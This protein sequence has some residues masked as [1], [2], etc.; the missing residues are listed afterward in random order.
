M[1]KYSAKKEIWKIIPFK[2]Y[3]KINIMKEVKHL[4]SEKYKSL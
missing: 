1:P 3:L 4:Y 2:N